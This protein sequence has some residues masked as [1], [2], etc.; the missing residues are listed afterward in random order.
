MIIWLASYPK[1]GNTWLRFLITSLLLKGR[2]SASLEQLGAIK[3]FPSKKQYQRLNI[4]NINYLDLNHISKYWIETQKLINT[5]KSI[6]F[7]K[8]HNALCKINNNI[9]T[10]LNNTLGVIYIVRD[11]RNVLTS[12][13]NHYHHENF[14]FS[15]KFI[16]DKSKGIINT[17]KI[18]TN[19][20]FA[21][22]QIIGSWKTHYN[23]WKNMKKNYLLIKYENLLL[24]PKKEFRKIT[25]YLQKLLNLKFSNTLINKAIELSSFKRLQ[26]IEEETGFSESVLD[27]KSGRRKQ[28]FHL[29]PKNDWHK[30]LDRTISNEIEKEF[31]NEMSELGYL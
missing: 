14:E 25:N 29:G 2:G 7:F 5:D 24:N 11:P 8:T 22:P 10:D 28:F 27:P 31:Y 18:T 15:K 19:N 3:Q 9:F 6:K 20:D 23:S 16:L 12:L 30:I 21:L 1:S 4:E 26:T 17:S 13:N